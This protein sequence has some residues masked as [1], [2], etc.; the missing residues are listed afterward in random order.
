VPREIDKETLVRLN[1]FFALLLVAAPLIF[2]AIR[3]PTRAAA[4]EEGLWGFNLTLLL[5]C[6][7]TLGAVLGELATLA[8]LFWE[9]L[10]GKTG[11]EVAIHFDPESWRC[12][13]LDHRC[14][15]SSQLGGG[16]SGHALPKF[17]SSR[18]GNAR[19]GDVLWRRQAD[20]DG[21]RATGN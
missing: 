17:A 5:A 2:H 20:R 16:S 4:R 18:S 10:G 1:L 15:S 8:L 21:R 11:A 19:E 14:L 9:V 7:V 12:G 6:T 3:K 13:C